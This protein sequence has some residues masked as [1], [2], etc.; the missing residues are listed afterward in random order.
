MGMGYLCWV[1]GALLPLTGTTR[2][3]LLYSTRGAKA[4]WNSRRTTKACVLEGDMPTNATAVD[5]VT[6]LNGSVILSPPPSRHVAGEVRSW[7]GRLC[8][9]RTRSAYAEMVVR[10]FEGHRPW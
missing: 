8:D 3:P 10:L 9:Q 5:V 6:T 7:C 4:G 2:T 1:M